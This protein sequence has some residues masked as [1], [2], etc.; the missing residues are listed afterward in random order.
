VSDQTA[1]F[2][3][4]GVIV[5]AAEARISVLDHGLLYGDGVFE[6]IRFYNGQPFRLAAHLRRLDRCAAALRLQ[7]PYDEELLTQAVMRV[8]AAYGGPHGYLR[9]VV[10]RGEGRLGLDPR[11]C[12]KPNAFIIADSLAL[13]SDDIRQRGARLI[14]AATRRLG[15]DGLDPRIKSLNYLNHILA[16]MEANNADADE[17]ILLN[18]NGHVAEGTADNVFVL[19]DGVILTPPCSDGALEGITREVVMDIARSAGIQVR[20]QSLGPFDL[21]TADECFL[22][23]TGAELIPVREIDGRMLRQC[24]GPQFQQ[25]AEAFRA[26]VGRE[27]LDS[28]C[29]TAL[30]L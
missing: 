15:A 17:A 26:L 8:I 23:G 12:S 19:R 1:R 21:Y 3:L 22:T 16:R 30:C 27:T 10:T 5:P 7:I 6:G 13:V 28:Q 9:L 24:P 11:S 29:H 4:N 14:V 20:E 2:W 25:L 18:H